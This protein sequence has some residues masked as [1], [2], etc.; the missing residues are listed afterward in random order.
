[1]ERL[2]RSAWPEL[3]SRFLPDRPG[4][5]VGLHAIHT[6][7]GQCWV[8]RWPLPRAGVV[9]TGG[10]LTCWGEPGALEPSALAGIVAGLLESWDRVFVEPRPGFEV[11]IRRALPAAPAWPRVVCVHQDERAWPAP[12]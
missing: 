7:C 11:V 4:P 3:R 2:D 1:M 10:N 8:D 5:L 9:V 6:G 12:E